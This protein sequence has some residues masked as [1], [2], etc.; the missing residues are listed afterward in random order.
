MS[1]TLSDQEKRVLNR[2]KEDLPYFA[3]RCLKIVTKEGK[4]EPLVFNEAQMYLHNQ[5]EKQLAEMGKVRLVICKGRQ[6]GCST[7]IAARKFHKALFKANK[8]IYILAHQAES[9]KWLYS[10]VKRYYENLPDFFKFPLVKDT[11]RAMEIDNGSVY[12]VGTAGSAQIGRGFTVQFLHAS[13]V[14]FYENTDKLSTGLMQA[15]ADV[16]GTEVFIESTA[17][18]PGNFFHSKVLTAMAKTTDYRLVF[19]PWYW[20]KEYIASPEGMELTPKEH[21]IYEA[22]HKEGMT[23][24]H[25]AWRRKKIAEEEGKEWKVD[26]EYPNNIEEAFVRADGRFMD[27]PKM[28]A[29]KARNKVEDQWAPLIIGVDPGRTGDDTVICRRVGRHVFPFETIKADDGYQRQMKLAGILA[30]II[31]QEQPDQV[32]IDPAEGGGAIDRLHELGYKNKVSRIHFG[33]GVLDEQYLNKRVEMAHLAKD[34]FDND[35]VSI[36]DD[37]EFISDL[38][39]IPEARL[40]SSGRKSIVSKDE[41]KKDLKRSPNK[42]DSFFLTFAM[43]VRKKQDIK[44][45]KQMNSQKSVYKSCLNTMKVLRNKS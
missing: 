45:A 12:S 43:P 13:E 27:I 11:D 20:Q 25:I 39:A 10:I 2:L 33:S 42:G 35:D 36:P 17:N 34:W 29:A 22:Y 1:L 4:V 37:Q 26:Q 40:T 14:A 32:F 41:I 23:L 16:P 44:V 15:V 24:S 6:Q 9:T 31:E 3:S 5:A 30:N 21:K 8:S 18:G 28:Y 7:Y 19:I 38:A